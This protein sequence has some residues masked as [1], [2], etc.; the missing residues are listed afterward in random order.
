M[1]EDCQYYCPNGIRS[2]GAP[3][4]ISNH[5]LARW[6]TIFLEESQDYDDS[7]LED[8][9]YEYKEGPECSRGRVGYAQMSMS[10]PS[11]VGL[12][13]SPSRTLNKTRV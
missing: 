4:K 8:Y 10:D 7:M 5:F 11:H 1:S 9:Q 3:P 2:S 6:K 13:G 12:Q